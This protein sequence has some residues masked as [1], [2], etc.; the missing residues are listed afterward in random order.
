M[1]TLDG[2]KKQ[3]EQIKK[4]IALVDKLLKLRE[5]LKTETA[6]LEEMSKSLSSNNLTDEEFKIASEKLAPQM[7]IVMNLTDRVMELNK[8][9]GFV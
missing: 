1:E 7:T 4:E 5:E 6:T 3:A 2:L 9:L 8:V